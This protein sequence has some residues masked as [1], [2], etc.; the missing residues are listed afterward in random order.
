MIAK[1]ALMFLLIGQA[2]PSAEPGA[3]E[4]PAATETVQPGEAPVAEPGAVE[5]APEQGITD[6]APA[7]DSTG[8]TQKKTPPWLMWVIL[9]GVLVVFYLL[10]IIPQRRRQKK[11][12][13]MLDSLKR[14]DNIITNGGIHGTIS[15][16]KEDTIVIKTAGKTELEIDKTVIT[17]KR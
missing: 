2:P 9:L 6:E 10:M 5:A 15:K 1:I 8:Q 3:V 16:I 4:Q 12:K 7:A 11:H 13:D 14:G 17:Q